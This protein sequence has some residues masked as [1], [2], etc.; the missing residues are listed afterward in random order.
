MTD[1]NASI[2]KYIKKAMCMLRRDANDIRL[3][4]EE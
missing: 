3:K 2:P 4:N 1:I